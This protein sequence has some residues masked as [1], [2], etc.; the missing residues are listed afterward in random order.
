MLAKER[1]G[2]A[3]QDNITEAVPDLIFVVS[4][5][6]NSWNENF[7]DPCFDAPSHGMRPA[8]GAIE[9]ARL[10]LLSRSGRFPHGL[11][12]GSDLV[13]RNATFR[14]FSAAVGVFGDPIYAW[15]G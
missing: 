15:A 2:I 1:K 3:F 13:G 11:A 7:P 9:S 14:E 4:A 8:C 10:M 5:F 12:N 6:N